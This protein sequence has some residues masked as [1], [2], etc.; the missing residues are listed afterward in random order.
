MSDCKNCIV[1]QITV[2][3]NHMMADIVGE[4]GITRAQVDAMKDAAREAQRAGPHRRA[5]GA[6]P[7]ALQ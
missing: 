4:K 2:N 7:S 6:Q 5:A 1:P 3:V